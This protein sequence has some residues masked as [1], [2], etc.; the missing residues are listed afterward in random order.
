MKMTLKSGQYET[1][2]TIERQENPNGMALL[3]TAECNGVVR[4][5]PMLIKTDSP[6]KSKEALEKEIRR[7]AQ[8]LADEAAGDHHHG[9]LLKELGL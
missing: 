2:I 3:I 5:K 4:S 1:E 7:N 9:G 8:K 6:F